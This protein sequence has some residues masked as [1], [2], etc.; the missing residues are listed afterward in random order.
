M[1]SYDL[2]AM[3]TLDPTE[4]VPLRILSKLNQDILNQC[5]NKWRI[6]SSAR[7]I[8]FLDEMTLRYARDE[9][10]VV[11]CV[12]EALGDFDDL[13]ERLPVDY[14]PTVDVSHPLPVLSFVSLDFTRS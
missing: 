2:E 4:E 1:L 11:E 9:M 7:F 12:M 3:S 10:P 8:A 5:G 13:N 14:W 6:L